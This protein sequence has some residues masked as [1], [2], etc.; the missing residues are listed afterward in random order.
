MPARSD[1]KERS[2][3]RQGGSA[4]ASPRVDRTRS[5]RARGNRLS[6]TA[7]SPDGSARSLEEELARRRRWALARD[8]Q[9]FRPV[10]GI[11]RHIPD[12]RR[13]HFPARQKA[14]R[15][16]VKRGLLDRIP[17]LGD[18][19]DRNTGGDDRCRFRQQTVARDSRGRAQVEGRGR[20]VE[21]IARRREAGD[22]EEK[23]DPRAAEE[24]EEGWPLR[25]GPQSALT[26]PVF[27][28]PRDSFDRDRGSRPSVFRGTWGSPPGADRS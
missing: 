9:E 27:G 22:R 25:R 14:D 28:G 16:P 3:G 26:P 13:Q 10:L 20:R 19:G 5:S 12:C 8:D 4:E 1:R 11:C 2:A 23:D 21:E 15:L 24:E 6:R 7:P 18:R 17:R